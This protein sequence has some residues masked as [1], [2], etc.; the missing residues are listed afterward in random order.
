MYEGGVNVPMIAFGPGIQRGA[1]CEALVNTTDLY[2]TLLELGG[3][4]S[5]AEDSISMVPYL[6]NPAQPSIRNWAYSE[7][8]A[9]QEKQQAIRG[10]RYKLIRFSTPQLVTTE[11][12]D[13]QVDPFE[14][15]NLVTIGLHPAQ[16]QAYLQLL[17]LLP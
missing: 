12:Y 9:G 14:Q 16:R 17:M 7:R 6:Q 4:S 1:E 11:F 13:L 3:A 8:F 5:Q 10:P 15:T 2:A